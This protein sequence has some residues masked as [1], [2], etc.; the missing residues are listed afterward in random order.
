MTVTFDT[1]AASR[2]RETRS[3]LRNLDIKPS[4]ESFVEMVWE[5]GCYLDPKNY[6]VRM[7]K[8]IKALDAK[9]LELAEEGVIISSNQPSI[10]RDVFALATIKQDL[11]SHYWRAERITA[12]QRN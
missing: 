8:E 7:R 3:T 5:D 6:N 11:I 12:D 10:A 2:Y 1:Q 4:V 9:I